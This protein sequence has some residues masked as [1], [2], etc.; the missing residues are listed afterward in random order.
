MVALSKNWTT[1]AINQAFSSAVDQAVQY[2]EAFY[3]F[4]EAHRLAGWTVV[5]SSNGVVANA[6]DNIASPADVVYGNAAQARSWAVLQPPAAFWGYAGAPE[7]GFLM[8]SA[9]N[10]NTDTTPQEIEARWVSDGTWDGAA[11][12]VTANPTANTATYPGLT[13]T[14]FGSGFRTTFVPWAAPV[15]GYAAWWASDEGDVMFGI[16]AAGEIGWRCWYMAR[17]YTDGEPQLGDGLHRPTFYGVSGVTAG[18]GANGTNLATTPSWIGRSSDNISLG[19]IAARS[20][21]WNLTSWT[22]GADQVRG[23]P[24]TDILL[25]NNSSFGAARFFGRIVDIYG[26]AAL[27]AQNEVQDGDADPIR[28]VCCRG[29]ATGGLWL[30]VNAVDLPIL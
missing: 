12:V 13:N 20:H 22:D 7:F 16:K 19:A 15:A 17:T 6:A 27:A 10:V 30:P 1:L 21:S 9:F 11:Y 26:C 29:S 25:F 3:W 24:A 8:V 14:Q 2:R 18:G 28:L 23:M 4:V 5:A